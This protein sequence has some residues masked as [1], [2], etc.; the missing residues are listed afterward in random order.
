MFLL[1]FNLCVFRRILRPAR[2][3]DE[4][5]GTK[6][7][8]DELF[9]DQHVAFCLKK[10]NI[11]DPSHALIQCA[12]AQ[13]GAACVTLDHVGR[14]RRRRGGGIVRLNRKTTQENKGRIKE[15]ER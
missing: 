14:R 10:V 5:Q 11:N 1:F 4:K 6:H 9:S 8:D 15:S 13:G 12:V 3:D 7:E 2:G